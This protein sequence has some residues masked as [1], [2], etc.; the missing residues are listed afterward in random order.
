M[1]AAGEAEVHHANA[2]VGADHHVVG[3]EV[4]V[5]QAGGVGRRD[6]EGDVLQHAQDLGPAA[7]ALAGPRGQRLSGDELHRDPHTRAVGA[8]VV[9]RDDVRVRQ[10]GERLGL[11]EQ[12]RVAV[13]ALARE[14]ELE[15][16]LAVELRVVSGVDDTH[17]AGADPAE[18]DVTADHGAAGELRRALPVRRESRAAAGR[19]G[20]GVVEPGPG[21]LRGGQRVGGREEGR[22]DG[23]LGVLHCAHSAAIVAGSRPM[24][25]ARAAARARAGAAARGRCPEGQ[26][27]SEGRLAG[28]SCD[29]T[30]HPHTSALRVRRAERGAACHPGC[31]YKSIRTESLQVQRGPAPADPRRRPRASAPPPRGR[32]TRP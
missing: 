19:V 3:L 1:A 31:N 30:H 24:I 13:A 9:D 10:A 2:A 12:P 26:A 16:D 29:N 32:A 8:N 11:A 20:E 22:A 15:G 25:Q 28:A 18:H 17:A 5:D 23:R 7:R 4:A 27:S 21:E 14:D 6:A